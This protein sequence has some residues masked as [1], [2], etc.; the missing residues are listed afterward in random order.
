MAGDKTR[1]LR[2][3]PDASR[4]GVGRVRNRLKR[5]GNSVELSRTRRAGRMNPTLAEYGVAAFET[6]VTVGEIAR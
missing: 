3:D 1:D 2:S 6:A 4:M 5:L